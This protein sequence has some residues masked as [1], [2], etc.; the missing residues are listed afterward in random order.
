MGKRGKGETSPL[1]AKNGPRFLSKTNDL[2]TNTRSLLLTQANFLH[3]YTAK[4]FCKT[5]IIT[6]YVSLWRRVTNSFVSS[7]TGFVQIINHCCTWNKT[8]SN[9]VPKWRGFVVI[10]TLAQKKFCSVGNAFLQD[11]PLTFNSVQVQTR[12]SIA[13]AA[14]VNGILTWFTRRTILTLKAMK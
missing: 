5:V 10:I 7:T 6:K 8:F 14:A 9:P 11:L 13:A 1:N 4:L 3:I 12:Y 2:V